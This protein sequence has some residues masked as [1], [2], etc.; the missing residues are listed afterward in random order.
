MTVVTIKAKN[1]INEILQRL[2]YFV[3]VL[4]SVLFRVASGRE[5]PE[6]IS[7]LLD[8]DANPRRPQYA[9]ASEIPLNLFQCDF[10]E[11]LNWVFD[12]EAIQMSIKQIQDLWTEHSVKSA[13][14]KD[15]LDTLYAKASESEIDVSN[16]SEKQADN[17]YSLAKSKSYISLK[18]MM[19]CPSLDE[20]LSSS[21]GKRRK[22]TK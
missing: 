16:G 14:F 11:K 12:E 6:I 19:K 5:S 1:I 8:I 2:Y 13:M 20:K 21:S 7:E 4:V 22:I 18:E 17:L 10:D 15:T 3:S 9:I